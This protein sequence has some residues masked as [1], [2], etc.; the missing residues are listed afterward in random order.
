MK[1]L[2][3][4]IYFLGLLMQPSSR[5]T[6]RANKTNRS[7]FRGAKTYN[8]EEGDIFNASFYEERLEAG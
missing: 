6:S 2:S 7:P 4:F 8:A 1:I 3:S 5:A